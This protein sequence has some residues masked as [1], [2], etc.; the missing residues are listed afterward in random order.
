MFFITAGSVGFF[1][2]ASGPDSAGFH[3]ILI[4]ETNSTNDEC[5]N[6]ADLG[7]P[8]GTLVRALRQTGGRGRSGRS[9]HSHPEAS[10][11]FSVLFRPQP[12]EYPYLTRFTLLGCLALVRVLSR[13]FGADPRIKWPNDV[14]LE[15]KKVSGVLVE[16]L[17]QDEIPSALVLGMGVNLNDQALPPQA[18][19]V[20]PAGSLEGQA[21][22]H[23]TPQSLLE[24]LLP[25][26]RRARELL[27]T[28]GFIEEINTCLAF[29]GEW[30]PL[31]TNTETALWVRLISVADDGSLWAEG[32]DGLLS[33]RYSA[34][35]SG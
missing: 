13:N 12:R 19:A 21:H 14:L 24:Y 27:P 17:W 3:Q 6:L 18:D 35:I 31:R 20:Y 4:P 34:E 30:V 16:T 1:R 8:D 23:T 26:L 33:R 22:I 7:A 25:E 2:M 11:T 28:P 10:L 5:L 9:W 29:K 32:E 15:G